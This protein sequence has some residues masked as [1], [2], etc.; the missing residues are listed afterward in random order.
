MATSTSSLDDLRR[1]ID[2]IDDLLHDLVMQRA[3]IVEAIANAKKN[4]GVA[5]IRPGR[6]ALILR[7]LIERHSGRFPRSALVRIWRE[8]MSGAVAMQVDFAVAVYAPNEM[9][10]YWDLARDHYGNSTKMLAF[11]SVGEVLRALVEGRVALGVLPMPTQGEKEPW[12]H[13]LAVSGAA[14]PRVVVRLP[15]AG[16]GSVRGDSVDALV[17]GQVEPDPTGAD[18]SLIVV[19]TTGEL[20]RASLVGALKDGGLPATF[21]SAHEE[22][23]EVVRNLIEIDDLVAAD[24]PRLDQALKPLGEKVARVTHIG[25]YARPLAAAA[26]D[27]RAGG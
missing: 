25:V 21:L 23:G 13:L 27:A 6:E 24:D 10:A 9:P 11:Q 22:G 15:F 18:C 3:E 12:W 4:N 20:S 19:K 8:L 5:T 17:I 7:R 14:A 1:R 26:L 2:Q 16:R